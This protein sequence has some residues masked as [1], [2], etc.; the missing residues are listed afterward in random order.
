[1]CRH[2]AGALLGQGH[3]RLAF[4]APKTRLA[5]D[6]ESEAGFLEGVTQARHADAKAIICHHDATVTGISQLVRRLMQQSSPPTALLVANAYHY[7]TVVSQ[8]AQLGRRV[9]DDVSV[10][11]RDEDPF[12]SFMV[13]APSR[14]V[15]SPHA[16][17]KS[18]LRPVLELLESG[19]I[20]QRAQRLMPAFIR[21]ETIGPAPT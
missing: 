2:A 1:M 13:P 8:L 21:G 3:R 4:L 6:I 7:L 18:M 17:A 15:A 14:Y 5:G 9:P 10:I 20:S 11:S 12:L 19:A 16:F